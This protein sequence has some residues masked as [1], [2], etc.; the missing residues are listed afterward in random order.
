MRM[1]FFVGIFCFASVLAAEAA[2]KS[3]VITNRSGEEIISITA[4]NKNDPNLAIPTTLA[5]VIPNQDS[6]DLT[7]DLPPETCHAD[8]TINFT[9][10]A[11]QVQQDIDLCNLDG[12]VV[13]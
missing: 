12:L 6:A 3:L 8:L 10:G 5:E 2:D 9:S 1:C 7:I 13:E 11:N 4:A